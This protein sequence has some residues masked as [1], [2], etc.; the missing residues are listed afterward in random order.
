MLRGFAGFVYS[1]NP[2]NDINKSFALWGI[3]FGA[4]IIGVYGLY[5]GPNEDFVVLWLKVFNVGFI[6]TPITFMNFMLTI[7]RKKT[8]ESLRDHANQA[9]DQATSQP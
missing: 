9:I 2:G 3:S 5:I 6:T 4:F 8:A 1:K 7:A